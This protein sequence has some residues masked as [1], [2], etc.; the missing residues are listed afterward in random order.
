MNFG[1]QVTEP[2]NHLPVRSPPT[3]PLTH[4]L[5]T[6][7]TNQPTPTPHCPLPTAHQGEDD[8]ALQAALAMSMGGEAPAGGAAAEPEEVAG[9]GLTADFQGN[10]ELFGITT[11]KVSARSGPAL[12]SPLG[13]CFRPAWVLFD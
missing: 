11:H 2:H 10:Y 8:A 5:P 9:P 6:L 3:R 1:I 12:V 13:S 4:P 7:L